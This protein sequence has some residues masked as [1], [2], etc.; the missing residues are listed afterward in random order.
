MKRFAVMGCLMAAAFGG[1]VLADEKTAL[2]ELEGTYTVVVLEKDGKTAE[3]EILEA[4]K[5]T[6]KG[7]ELTMFIDKKGEKDEKKAKVK[8][9]DSKTPHTIDV[10]PA[11]GIDKGKMF[12]GIY[13]VEKGEL[14]LVFAERGDR[15]KEFKS[16]NATLLKLKKNEK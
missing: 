7:D 8:L 2:K 3:K 12:P 6:I 10:T 11:D 16:E 14:T 1:I 9:D 4:V 5:V 15:P 13:K